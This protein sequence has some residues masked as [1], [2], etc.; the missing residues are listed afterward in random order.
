MTRSKISERTNLVQAQKFRVALAQAMLGYT[1][2]QISTVQMIT[3][4]LELAKL[5]RSGMVRNSAS[6]TKRRRFTTL[7]RRTDRP[8]K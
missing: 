8:K 5:R 2:K 7:W 4:L 3:H 6:A 1:N